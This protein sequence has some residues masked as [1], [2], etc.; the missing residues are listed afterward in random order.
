MVNSQENQ[1]NRGLPSRRDFLRVGGFALFFSFLEAVF[2]GKV[3]ATGRRG[4]SATSKGV[5]ES[6]APNSS[7][8]PLVEGEPPKDLEVL[9]AKPTHH[10][11]VLGEGK[12]AQKDI[13]T[14]LGA[15][16]D[17][18]FSDLPRSGNVDLLQ[19]GAQVPAVAEEYGVVTDLAQEQNPDVTVLEHITQLVANAGSHAQIYLLGH[20][21]A[22]VDDWYMQLGRGFDVFSQVKHL[23]MER[24]AEAVVVGMQQRFV[25]NPEEAHL[26]IT[27]FTDSCMSGAQSREGSS[28]RDSTPN[29]DNWQFFDYLQ[30]QFK[31]LKNPKIASGLS[32]AMFQ[33]AT[34]YVMTWSSEKDN[35]SMRV[36]GQLYSGT[37]LREILLNPETHKGS[38]GGLQWR[39]LLQ[40]GVGTEQQLFFPIYSSNGVVI[41]GEEYSGIGLFDSNYLVTAYVEPLFQSEGGTKVVIPIIVVNSTGETQTVVLNGVEQGTIAPQASTRVFAEYP[42]PS[43]DL[44]VPTKVTVSVQVG[45]TTFALQPD[46]KF[47]TEKLPKCT[48]GAVRLFRPEIAKNKISLTF[49][50]PE[51]TQPTKAFVTVTFPHS[52]R[53]G[54]NSS[55]SFQQELGGTQEITIVPGI[56][57]FDLHVAQLDS[58][59]Y[60]FRLLV[61]D[62]LGRIIPIEGL[63]NYLEV[64]DNATFEDALKNGSVEPGKYEIELLNR[65][66]RDND[67]FLIPPHH[68][69]EL[70]AT[71]HLGGDPMEGVFAIGY[72]PDNRTEVVEQTSIPP[73]VV[74]RLTTGV[75]GMVLLV[76]ANSPWRYRMELSKNTTVFLPDV[77][78]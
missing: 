4:A 68:T 18:L 59:V 48:G 42:P 28:E 75:K 14:I 77:E 70:I 35:F 1:N 13:N 71:E 66:F 43:A 5:P 37:T 60:P 64:M 58:A 38:F 2:S 73:D 23:S 20:G 27:V 46:L 25:A 52:K 57:N 30:A 10:L 34:E 78:R 40:G 16:Y 69:I 22:G 51:D 6:P 17:K 65:G 41:R 3:G 54:T 61:H 21:D 11:M 63:P 32:M 49:S 8:S 67:Y 55:L 39:F 33:P 62:S 29:G 44:T 45:E 36:L 72:D 47:A 76:T 50:T 24:M 74:T 15:W 12:S 7:S 26:H 9:H 56:N 19:Y 31:K 53:N